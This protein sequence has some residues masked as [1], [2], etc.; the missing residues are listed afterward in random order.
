MTKVKGIVMLA[1]IVAGLITAVNLQAVEKTN[2]KLV[3]ALKEYA[4]SAPTEAVRF[5]RLM[6]ISSY[7]MSDEEKISY[8][9]D[10]AKSFTL[11]S[12]KNSIA[13]AKAGIY[14]S[15]G[16]V[17]DALA[18]YEGLMDNNNF[19]YIRQ[20]IQYETDSAIALKYK[21]AYLLNQLGVRAPSL[22][23]NELLFVLKS[24]RPDE[25]DDYA[26]FLGDIL[27]FYRVFTVDSPNLIPFITQVEATLKQVGAVKTDAVLKQQATPV[28]AP[29]S[30]ADKK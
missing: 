24:I 3:A 13:V 27:K 2:E 12:Q 17:K 26:A 6:S 9:D 15:Q 10:L 1:L 30:P 23:S 8:Y 14:V 16:R 4:E 19:S 29:V 18:V 11:E 7:L 20:I 28:P 25:C 5:Q 21:K 22:N